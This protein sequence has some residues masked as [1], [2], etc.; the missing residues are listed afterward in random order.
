MEGGCQVEQSGHEG[1]GLG[2]TAGTKCVGML[3]SLFCLYCVT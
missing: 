1:V 3:R 2:G